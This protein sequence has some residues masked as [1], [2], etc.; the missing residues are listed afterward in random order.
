MDVK[1]IM[2]NRTEKAER[3]EGD[4]ITRYM[5]TFVNAGVSLPTGNVIKTGHV[6]SNGVVPWETT[7]SQ[8]PTFSG[9][10]GFIMGN[11]RSKTE[12]LARAEFAKEFEGGYNRSML[13]AGAQRELGQFVEGLVG[14]DV[15]AGLYGQR[16]RVSATTAGTR[17]AVAVH[18]FGTEVGLGLS[19]DMGKRTTF[20]FKVGMRHNFLRSDIT[21][22]NELPR[23]SALPRNEGFAGVQ[24]THDLTRK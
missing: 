21:G 18:G 3:G 6:I 14:L 19:F 4:T 7:V 24:L 10:F 23:I 5:K 17:N 2:H 11:D 12:F 9:G 20:A 1:I 16:N 8:T 13:F 15:W 22:E